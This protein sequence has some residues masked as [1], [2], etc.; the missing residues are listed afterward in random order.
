[1][2]VGDLVGHAYFGKG[3]VVSVTDSEITVDFGFP[4]GLKTVTADSIHLLAPA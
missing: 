3:T 2:A 4:Y 1:M